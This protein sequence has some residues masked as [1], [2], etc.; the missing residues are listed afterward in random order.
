MLG[1]MPWTLY[2][3]ILRDVLALLLLATAT[4][5]TVLSFAVAI[6][7]LS[8]GLLG[9]AAL[10]RFVVLMMPWMLR[11][12]LPF[13]AAFA[14]T[15]VFIRM[16][17]DNEILACLA[18][19]ISYR[20][21]LGPVLLVGVVLG[22]VQFGLAHLVVPRFYR[23]A[24]SMLEKDLL[25]T[26]VTRIRDGKPVEV[27]EWVVYADDAA[28][29]HDPPEV[30]GSEVQPDQLVVLT[31]MAL[32]ERDVNGRLRHRATCQQAD[33]F[34][35]RVEGRGWV[36]MQMNNVVRVDPRRGELEDVSYMS[37]PAI[38][39]PS[40]LDDDPSFMTWPELNQLRREPERYD[41]V[42]EARQEL[43]EVLARRETEAFV[44]TRLRAEDGQLLLDGP[45]ELTYQVM[46]PQVRREGPIL[47]LT[48][49]EEDPVT[50]EYLTG[51]LLTRRATAER[52][53]IR[54]R[55]DQPSAE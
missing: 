26:M 3:Y 44:L 25:E 32:G 49:D 2:R 14:A 47:I 18:G 12:A 42:W 31:G 39:L 40:P 27:Q 1:L 11:I 29:F 43:V 28:V 52:G 24:K 37:V 17:S 51:G 9:P 13:A 15:I 30:P 45:G 16:A 33:M 4:L 46:A 50:I 5:V 54:V 6:K 53:E 21:L 10:V 48:G 20:G 38:R 19:G 8:E 36:T 7:P 34:L 23:A 35:Y 41:S 55:A 22:G